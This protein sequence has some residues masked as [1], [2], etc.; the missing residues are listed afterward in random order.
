[1]SAH[2]DRISKRPELSRLIDHAE[3]HQFD[4]VVVHTLDRWARNMRVQTEALQILG[5]ARVGFASVTE[6]IDYTTAEGKLMLTMIGGFA[7][8]FSAQ[9]A[10]HVKKAV[11]QR[12]EHGLPSGPVPFG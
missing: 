9:L 8:L 10:R 3:Q 11:R 6:N 2:T 5:D 7:E 1:M 4:I 12:V